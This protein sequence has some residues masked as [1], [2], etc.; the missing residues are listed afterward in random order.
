MKNFVNTDKIQLK[1]FTFNYSLL[2][3]TSK[4]LLFIDNGGRNE[5]ENNMYNINFINNNSIK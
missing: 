5:K 2:T 1:L 4:K 3:S